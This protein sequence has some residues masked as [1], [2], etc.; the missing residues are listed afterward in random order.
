MQCGAPQWS[1]SPGVVNAWVGLSAVKS[2]P[3]PC[4][5]DV[6]IE[7]DHADDIKPDFD[8]LPQLLTNEPCRGRANDLT[9][10]GLANGFDRLAQIVSRTTT[11]FDKHDRSRLGIANDDVELSSSERNISRD[12]REASIDDETRRELL[13]SRS[14]VSG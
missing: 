11:N 7:I 4:H 9:T 13:G 12:H 3:E 2:V 1:T 6:A 14:A 8:L 10:L 5:L